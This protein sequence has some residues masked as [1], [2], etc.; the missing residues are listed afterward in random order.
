MEDRNMI[1]RAGVAAVS[2]LFALAGVIG[3]SASPAQAAV[4]F[5]YAGGQE[6]GISVTGINAK[7]RVSNPYL[8]ANTGE[9]TL[10][11]LIV[12]DH[13]GGSP[14]N[15][16]EFGWI[17]DG[18]G[19]GGP[20]LFTYYWTGGSPQN[21]YYGCAA[22]HDNA[23][24]P[25]NLGADLTAVAGSCVGPSLACIKNFQIEY[26]A[27][28]CGASAAGT[29]MTYDGTDVG[30]I[31]SAALSS[32]SYTAA[33]GF[34]EVA[35]TGATVPCTDMGNGKYANAGPYNSLSPAVIQ[36]V[37]YLG[38]ATTPT[39][40]LFATDTNAYTAV[41]NGSTGNR[42]Y[43]IGGAGYTSTGTSPGNTGSC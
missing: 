17:K 11:E 23:G 25:I 2:L 38:T 40:T 37:T 27:S 24:N 6:T 10:M 35:Y 21:C 18:S 29:F 13:P 20:R 19:A 32:T 36:T 15:A 43:S 28:T 14:D 39:F 42:N 3:L 8:Q 33:Q 22:W 31:D 30:C 4:S 9:H 1:K 41:S 12:Q 26:R 16:A 5:Y 7:M 34:G